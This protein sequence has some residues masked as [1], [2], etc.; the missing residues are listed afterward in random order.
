MNK[1]LYAVMIS[2]FSVILILF[3][4]LILSKNLIKDKNNMLEGHTSG[5]IDKLSMDEILKSSSVIARAVYSGD[6]KTI[7]V[8]SAVSGSELNFTDHYLLRSRF[9]A[10]RSPI[11]SVLPSAWKAV[12]LRD[13]M[14][15]AMI[16]RSLKKTRNISSVFI[17]PEDIMNTTPRTNITTLPA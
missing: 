17:I 14:K 13:A 12:L 5:L 2:V 15:Y 7:R 10:A 1:K 16:I 6:S 3:L 8:Q 4:A 11:Q 9:C